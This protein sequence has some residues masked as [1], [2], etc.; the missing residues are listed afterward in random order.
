MIKK[1]CNNFTKDM[2]YLD[3]KYNLELLKIYVINKLL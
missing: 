1:G 3:K 2:K